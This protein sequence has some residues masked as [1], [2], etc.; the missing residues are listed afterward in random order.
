MKLVL[1]HDPERNHW[2]QFTHPRTV[3]QAVTLSDVMP[4]LAEV[5]RL[6]GCGGLYAAGWIGYEAAPA[7][8]AAF[9][10]RQASAFP[11]ACFGIFDPPQIL[12]ALPAA[13]ESSFDLAWHPSVSRDEYEDAIARIKNHVAAGDTY[14]VNY[15]LRQW[16]A[17]R[18]DPWSFFLKTC[19]DARYGAFVDTGRFSIC[20]A[21][22]ELFFSLQGERIFSKPMKGTAARG[23]NSAEDR[24]NGRWLYHSEKN[25]AENVMIVDMI[26]NDLGRV[27][28]Y[29]SVKV[30][31]LFDI[32]T[33]PTVLQMTS[34][35]EARTAST[36]PEILE[37]LFPCAS[38]TGAPKAKTMEI[39]AA[40]E[41]TPRNIYTG[42]I[43]CYGPGRR[44]LFNVA[45]RTTLIDKETSRAEYGVGG[46]IVWDST[47]EEEYEECLTKAGIILNPTSPTPFD[48]LETL[49]WT[50]EEGFFLL[51]R[52]LHRLRD[53]ALYFDYPY[54]EQRIL[55]KLTAAVRPFPPGPCRIRLLLSKSGAV[56]CR[57]ASLGPSAR[58][59]LR[60]RIAKEAVSSRDPFLF[61]KTTRRERYEKAR[62]SWPDADDVLLYNE[63]GEVTESCIAN[64]VILRDGRWVTPPVH[65]GLLNGT[66]RAE[67]LENGEISEETVSLSELRNTEKIFLIN[68]V[69]KWREA[70]LPAENPLQE[71]LT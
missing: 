70:Y 67:L 55:D 51:S 25:R 44:A 43:G 39:I 60:L 13:G 71:P 50:P 47:A 26:R 65:C 5:Q 29:G 38:I 8:D 7:F 42:T 64:V 68:S 35:V 57:A 14:Q 69:R 12:T 34:T 66:Y 33:Y 40:S 16:S 4:L 28:R 30:P 2:M 17:F 27:A 19:A 49:L 63:R 62:A 46:G 48:L 31:R 6:V 9:S 53:S 56:E 24:E 41:T 15:T 3:L 52:H 11:L 36:L 22:P 23:M 61:H 32:E 10:T 21:S 45:I 59:P 20:S 58:S 37:A 54:D 18:E 1:I